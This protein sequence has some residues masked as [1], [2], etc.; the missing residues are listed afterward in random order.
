MQKRRVST[1]GNMTARVATDKVATS[2]SSAKKQNG[3]S[4]VWKYE[5]DKDCDWYRCI[6]CE[7]VKNFE[8]VP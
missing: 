1:N 7:K 6:K 4:H 8:Y 3:C 2:V 5:Q